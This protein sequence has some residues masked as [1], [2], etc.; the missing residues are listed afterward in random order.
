MEKNELI[1][2]DIVLCFPGKSAVCALKE[3]LKHKNV[4]VATVVEQKEGKNISYHGSDL[5]DIET[6]LKF[7]NDK[8]FIHHSMRDVGNPYDQYDFISPNDL[9]EVTKSM[10]E[11]INKEIKKLLTEIEEKRNEINI[12]DDNVRMIKEKNENLFP[13][14]KMGIKDRKEA[15]TAKFKVQPVQKPKPNKD[16]KR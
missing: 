16:I 9:D 14:V 12:I 8:E 7:E 4:Q 1:D 5:Y 13:K 10:K 2:D 11:N 15:A 6:T 3:P